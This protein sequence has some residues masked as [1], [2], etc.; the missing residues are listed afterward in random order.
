MAAIIMNPKAVTP[1][2]FEAELV[3]LDT[4]I[5]TQLPAT[6]VLTIN[7]VAV[8]QAEIDATLQGWIGSCRAV[9]TARTQ[10]ESAVAARLAITAVGRTYCK[11]LKGVVKS[12]FGPQSAALA[13]FG[14]AADKQ[15]VMTSTQKMVTVAKRSQTRKVRGT[16]GKKQ[17]AA[18]TVVGNPPVN[19]GSDGKLEVGAP[20]IN[21]TA[22]I[23]TPAP[24]TAPA[25]VGSGSGGGTPGSGTPTGA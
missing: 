13:A 15:V 5:R 14:I 8:T 22:T 20:P 21:L 6:A 3:A 11:L 9:E 7:G 2:V 12:Y 18:I 1:A 24:V 10:Y 4:G 17:K 19:V 16:K 23:G 25:P